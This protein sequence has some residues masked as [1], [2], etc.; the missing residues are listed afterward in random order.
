MNILI[1]G[2][3]LN[4]AQNFTKIPQNPLKIMIFHNSMGVK[5]FA[6]KIHIVTKRNEEM[7]PKIVSSKR[8]GCTRRV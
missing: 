8:V 6:I 3:L 5:Y 1:I 2:K 7:K 4:F